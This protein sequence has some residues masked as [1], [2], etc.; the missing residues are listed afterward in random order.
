MEPSHNG[1]PNR[2]I[3]AMY[4]GAGS[5]SIRVA[6]VAYVFVSTPSA[7]PTGSAMK[8]H[9]TTFRGSRDARIAPVTAT[10]HQA[11]V[12]TRRYA[13]GGRE[14]PGTS[15]VWRRSSSGRAARNNAI[16]K[17]DSDHATGRAGSE[18]IG[19]AA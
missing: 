15:V 12:A 13:N 6:N 5:G 2:P 1:F 9:P 19:R 7:S 17:I 16:A 18:I 10:T 11:N 4:A 14:R 3:Q 8:S